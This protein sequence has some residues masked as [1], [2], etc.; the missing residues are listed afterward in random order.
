MRNKI[1]TYV[2]VI[3]LALAAA[4]MLCACQEKPLE[5]TGSTAP[6]VTAPSVTEPQERTVYTYIDETFDDLEIGD[7][8]EEKT[9]IFEYYEGGGFI[10]SSKDDDGNVWI[11]AKDVND[12]SQWALAYT[13]V[14]KDNIKVVLKN[15]CVQ[16][17][18]RLPYTEGIS[19]DADGGA[20]ILWSP[21]AG[22][23]DLAMHHCVSTNGN[24]AN[25][26]NLW[27]AMNTDGGPMATTQHDENWGERGSTVGDFSLAEDVSYTVTIC[28]KHQGIDS[29]GNEFFTLYVFID[30]ELVIYQRDVTYWEGGFGLRGFIS[31]YEYA[32]FKV[33]DFPLV[34]P[35]GIDHWTEDDENTAY[36]IKNYEKLAAPEVTLEGNTLSWN[37]VEGASAYNI[38]FDGVRVGHTTDTTFDIS[39]V[40]GEGEISVSA[41]SAAFGVNSSDYASVP[42]SNPMPMP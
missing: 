28:G 39:Q 17:D 33:T 3:L 38:V 13:N 14:Y 35:D 31:P 30:D 20:C 6:S 15:F 32:N 2:R 26:L 34:C 23:Y 19:L 21:Q 40:Y 37:A 9:S 10:A 24:T 7:S 16:F 1:K 4:L 5:N 12:G 41:A 42:I 11:R 29:D 36:P 25:S 22:R 18:T 8:L 27:H